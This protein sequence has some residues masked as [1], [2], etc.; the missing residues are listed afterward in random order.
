MEKFDSLVDLFVTSV[1]KVQ[2]YICQEHPHE[3]QQRCDRLS[4]SSPLCT[5]SIGRRRYC[6]WF[7]TAAAILCLRFYLSIS[8]DDRKVQ[9]GNRQ[10]ESIQKRIG[11]PQGLTHTTF[12]S[13]AS[14]QTPNRRRPEGQNS[15]G[16]ELD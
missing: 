2:I 11:C 6:F 14:I 4:I 5:V 3:E 1:I 7:S 12:S 10:K 15:I 8:L 9:V 13:V 16:S